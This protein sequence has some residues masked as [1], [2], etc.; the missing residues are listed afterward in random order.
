VIGVLTEMCML[1]TLDMPRSPHYGV[2][3]RDTYRKGSMTA[4][5][6]GAGSPVCFQ[7]TAAANLSARSDP[8]P[9]KKKSERGYL[10]VIDRSGDSGEESDAHAHGEELGHLY[11]GWAGGCWGGE[12]RAESGGGR[13]KSANF[14]R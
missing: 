8:Q 5:P 11:G 4:S 9:R 13:A 6:S 14:L 1:C 10:A 2:P 7:R 12:Q 3:V